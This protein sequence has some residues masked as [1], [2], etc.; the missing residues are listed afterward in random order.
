MVL[1]KDG[2]DAAVVVGVCLIDRVEHRRLVA[3]LLCALAL[4]DKI[5]ATHNFA[6]KPKALA[7]RALEIVVHLALRALEVALIG[8]KYRGELFVVAPLELQSEVV[9][10]RLHVRLL[11]VDHQPHA[12]VRRT[13]GDAVQPLDEGLHQPRLLRV[14]Q[15]QAPRVRDGLGARLHGRQ[16]AKTQ[17]VR[18]LEKVELFV[19]ARVKRSKQRG[20]LVRALVDAEPLERLLE[21]R[22]RDRVAVTLCELVVPKVSHRDEQLGHALQEHRLAQRGE[23][24]R[25]EPAPAAERRVVDRLEEDFR[26][27][28]ALRFARVVVGPRRDD[29]C[30][31]LHTRVLGLHV[32]LGRVVENG[33]DAR[34]LEPLDHGLDGLARLAR[35]EV[36]KERR[37]RDRNRDLLAEDLVREC[38]QRVCSRHDRVRVAHREHSKRAQKLKCTLVSKD[39]FRVRKV[40][41]R[42]RRIGRC[43]FGWWCWRRRAPAPTCRKARSS[44]SRP[45][46]RPRRHGHGRR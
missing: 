46:E 45:R 35:A 14:Q 11:G 20:A 26:V 41:N 15:S 21:V 36:R 43:T 6:R 19:A 23:L 32:R 39:H 10:R 18:P 29:P 42:R 1:R 24:D 16:I 37:A 31:I 4:D 12:L 28:V 7:P 30:A 34:R 5:R 27:A 25:D 2:R 38:E 17:R 3:A 22:E 33:A 8:G 40:W 9:D 13:R 44:R